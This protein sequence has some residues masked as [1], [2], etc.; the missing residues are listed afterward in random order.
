MKSSICRAWLMA[1]VFVA[2]PVF[3]Q[4]IESPTPPPPSAKNLNLPTVIET[5]S[6]LS[7]VDE[8]TPDGANGFIKDEA[9]AIALG[10]AF[11]WDM[12]VG[13]DGVACG[14]CHYHAGA[15]ARD[16]NQLSPGIK[17]GNGVF[18]P[19]ATGG[20]PNHTLSAADFPLHLLLDPADRDSTV[21]L[22]TDDV[23][24]SQG[25]FAA[26]FND[27]IPGVNGKDGRADDDCTIVSPDP[28]GFHLNN[29]N[30]RRV[31]PR[32]TPTVINAAFNHRNFWDGRANNIFNGVDPFGNRNPGARV[33]EMQGANAVLIPVAFEN[34]SLASQSVGPPSSDFE[35]ACGE[36]PFT[37]AQR[38]FLKIGKKM[39][40]IEALSGQRVHPNDSVLGPLSA[41]PKDGLDGPG[42][43]GIP[44][45]SLIAA[46]ISDRFWNSNKL[47]DVDKIEI[48]S[49][50]PANTDQYTQMEAN[51]SLIWGLAIQSYLR[52]LVS[53]DAPYDQWA[54]ASDDR[55]PTEANT[56]GILTQ[57]Q[58]RGMNLFF[59][60][61]LADTPSKTG[62]RGNCS[63]CHQGP[64]FS[65]ATFP[66]TEEEDSGEFPEQEQIVERMKMGDGV[67]IAEDLFRFFVQGEGSVGGYALA[68]TAG[69]RNIPARYPAASGGDFSLNGCDADVY[70]FLMSQDT[71]PV[72]F[73]P[74]SVP[75]TATKD[76][77]I[78]LRNC[79]GK[80]YRITLIDGGPG[81]DS[82]SID[83]I[84]P[85]V[86][87][88]RGGPPPVIPFYPISVI[89]SVASGAIV[90]DFTLN[91]PTLYDTAF[92][93]IGVRPT[94]EDPG[95]G[96]DDLFGVPLS[97]TKQW[98]A[99]LLGT[100]VSDDFSS[101]TLARLHLP[102]NWFGDGVFFPGGLTG[103]EWPT[104]GF[105]P[106]APIPGANP[107]GI[108]G[109]CN[110]GIELGKGHE[111][112]PKYPTGFGPGV[113]FLQAQAIN[114]MNT[115]V[116][117]AF[118][119]PNLRNVTLTAPYFHNGGQLTL[120]Q[121]V[122][123]YDRGADFA[124]EN[125][126]DLAPNIHPLNLD[127]QQMD[128]IVAFLETLTD[129]RVACE[130]APF[131]HPAIRIANGARGDGGFV[132]PDNKKPGQSKD[133]L[134]LIQAVGAGGRPANSA[135]C[136]DQENFL[137]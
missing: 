71:V 122:E 137:Q 44:Y 51:F 32:N 73:P 54:E 11:Y 66:F 96:A 17:G 101:L 75:N 6:E 23:V 107:P 84:Q 95:V 94:T 42:N 21:L 106:C 60:N 19:T 16:T 63:T 24:S 116:G 83:E 110:T 89:A 80:W 119:V 38:N 82:A 57:Q 134:E 133:Q 13:S 27:V 58:M 125:L 74:F 47:F 68:G 118:K 78:V 103:P 70:Y 37:L 49:G 123:F 136:I 77:E 128:D 90:G 100:P 64:F 22:D 81:L 104:I 9:A 131:D 18:D 98:V 14:T 12:Q 2:A 52:T 87:P 45:A 10:K 67:N 31:E 92:Y 93:N 61:E 46:A 76:A 115:A 7:V 112:Y 53:D 130:K 72:P 108:F 97:F 105:F 85:I 132:T 34:S 124:I 121:V 36:D 33:I 41:H 26:N 117:G 102:F 91:Q 3:G 25:T 35:M 126:G 111:A 48:G 56:K 59:T 8:G 62:L 4:F 50:T 1:V 40:N 43:T 69:A 99:S 5:I 129:D 29:I 127:G 28:F 109:A 30:V 39:V 86:K 113:D 114:N 120:R 88:P 20:G 65:T 15:D 135:P 79:G 55:S